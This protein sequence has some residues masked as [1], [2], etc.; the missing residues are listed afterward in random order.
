M[1]FHNVFSPEIGRKQVATHYRPTPP[2]E[3]LQGPQLKY[4]TLKHL[5]NLTRAGD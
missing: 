3:D 5:K 1:G 2:E 4:D